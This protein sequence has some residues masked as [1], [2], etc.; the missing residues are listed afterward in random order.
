MTFTPKKTNNGEIINIT[1]L[2]NKYYAKIEYQP[3]DNYIVVCGINF[4]TEKNEDEEIISNITIYNP[5]GDI[6][7]IINEF[8]FLDK[9]GKDT[10]IVELK[11]NLCR[12]VFYSQYESSE[13]P[14]FMN[15]GF[16]FGYFS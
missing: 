7:N 10:L 6:P 15:M 13:P 4:N 1:Q 8:N 2:N 14:Y 16:S 11:E 3:F 9:D 5:Y 12:S